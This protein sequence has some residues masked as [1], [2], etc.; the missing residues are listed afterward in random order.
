MR[1]NASKAEDYA[2]RHGVPKWYDNAD[3]LLNDPDI[4]AVYIATPPSSHKDYVLKALGKGLHVYV[5]KPVA[6]NSLEATDIANAA[7]LSPAKLSV[8][9]YRRKLPSFRFVKELLD[10][11][12]IGDVRLVQINIR[13]PLKPALVALSQQNWRI[14][15]KYSGDGYFHDLAPHQLDLMLYFFGK[16]IHLNGFS[17][18][19]SKFYTVDDM[20]CGQMLFENNITF[21]GSWNFSIADKETKDEC[22]LIG[23]KGSI[24]FSFFGSDVT[25]KN[26]HGEKQH[27]HFENPKH[28]QEPMIGSVVK[29]F[30]REAENPCSID[31]AVIVMKMMDA[32]TKNPKH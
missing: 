3:R 23:N 13:Q 10:K 14:D 24:M 17:V 2:R 16:P 26:E 19:Q 7:K 32:F 5:E 15:P 12:T 31:E 20:V 4:N 30:C 27:H 9:H 29:Y 6:L 21:S 1:H 8:A 22:V 18:N 25:V 11:E 28:V